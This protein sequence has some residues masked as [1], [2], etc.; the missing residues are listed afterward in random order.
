MINKV[1]R[2]RMLPR[3]RLLALTV[4]GLLSV[5]LAQGQ[6]IRERDMVWEKS[7]TRP[8]VGKIMSEPDADPLVIDIGNG[9]KATIKRGNVVRIKRSQNAQQAYLSHAKTLKESD[10]T[11][12]YKLAQWCVDQELLEPAAAE[13]VKSL[14]A[15][16]KLKEAYELAVFISNEQLEKAPPGD[17]QELLYD[18]LLGVVRLAVK[19]DCWSPRVGLAQGR[20]LLTLNFYEASLPVFKQVI[21]ELGKA[22]SPSKVQIYLIKK[23]W[24]G[25]GQGQLSLNQLEAAVASMDALIVLDAESFQG[26]FQRGQA[27]SR[28]GLYE[29]ASAD[30]NKALSIE[31]AYA[32]AYVER[33]LCL[34][35]LNRVEEAINDLKQALA[36]GLDDSES[37]QTQLGLLY[38]RLGKLKSA[39]HA[40]LR[41]RDDRPFAPA[42]VGLALILLRKDKNEEALAALKKAES[43]SPL[44]GMPKALRAQVLARLGRHEEAT[45]AYQE[46]LRLG[47]NVKIGLRALASLASKQSKD[48]RAAQWL[49]YLVSNES[50]KNAD[51]CY[52]LGRLLLKAKS[53]DRAREVFEA[54]L[55]INKNHV[56]SLSGLGY[57]SYVEKSYKDAG[58]YFKSVLLHDASNLYAKRALK[59]IRESQTRKVWSDNFKREGPGVANRWA[60]TVGFGVVIQLQKE[61][62]TFSGIQAN[63]DMGKTALTRKIDD[64]EFVRFEATLD[65]GGAAN[66]RIGIRIKA[67]GAEVFLFRSEDGTKLLGGFKNSATAA[68]KITELG[69]WPGDLGKR[70]FALEVEDD[71]KGVVSFHLD[72]ERLGDCLV[73]A[74]RRVKPVDIIIYGQS[75]VDQKWRLGLL[76]VRVFVKKDGAQKNA[77]SG[78]Y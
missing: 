28:Q 37:V 8:H 48:E 76:K 38:L 5:S 2:L 71:N 43:L 4:I 30:L 12:H 49:K 17:Q 22:E 75:T 54:A 57:L 53:Y 67:R 46:A 21:G 18:R 44:D 6:E 34:T 41:T 68:P 59:N 20:A 32:E 52:R 55:K 42:E 78:G 26:H 33:A 64:G 69:A 1:N 61:Q 35:H 36:L 51:D 14:A 72:G 40:F 47:F 74:F 15:D 29:K 65:T 16:S 62:V 66:A 27:R 23:A 50:L 45:R 24:I 9:V 60:P 77:K 63:K 3:A 31:V 11:G 73:G 70:D 56:P 10:G 13:L 19:N 25:L 58:G 7:V 39:G